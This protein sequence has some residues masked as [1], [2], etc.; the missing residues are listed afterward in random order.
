MRFYMLSIL[1][2]AFLLF[3]ASKPVPDEKYSSMI[4]FLKEYL[5]IKYSNHQFN[6]FL[7][8]AAKQ[9]KMFHIKGNKV[10]AIYPVSTAKKGIGSKLGSNQTPTGLHVVKEKV[11]DGIPLA[12]IL[13]EKTY[14]GQ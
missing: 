3:T 10:V 7:Y 11:G 9:Q 13:R 8:V 6:E 4:S 1:L 14:T 5:E 12:G 2:A